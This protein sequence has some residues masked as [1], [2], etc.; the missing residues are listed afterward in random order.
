MQQCHACTMMVVSAYDPLHY[1]VALIV[2]ESSILHNAITEAVGAI[3]ISGA[4]SDD[5]N[6]TAERSGSVALQYCLAVPSVEVL[7]SS[8]NS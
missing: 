2:E 6:P 4:N 7:F 3:T 1:L 5:D 8:P